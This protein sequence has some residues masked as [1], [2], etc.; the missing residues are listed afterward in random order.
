[1]EKTAFI[2]L[3]SSNSGDIYVFT[4]SRG[5]YE[6]ERTIEYPGNNSSPEPDVTG[7]G[8]FLLSLP[9]ELLNFR[10]LKL[11]F[12][13]KD[14][15]LKVVP[16]ELESLMMESPGDVVFDATVL[17]G[18]GEQFDVLV[19]YIGKSVLQDILNKLGLL[20]IDPRIVTC[21]ELRAVMKGGA[22][23]I[24]SRLLAPGKM[25]REQRIETA[26]SELLNET[27]N[28]RTG[29]LAYTKDTE[30]N[31]RKLK[32][33]AVLLLLLVL[34]VDSWLAFRIIKARNETSAVKKEL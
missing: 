17:G 11:P 32:T 22:E 16:F 2:D 8:E 5:K 24:A 10:L 21:L 30:K 27:V 28:L 6:L 1:M 29:T 14:K 7:V 15:L 18:A 25:G 33:A 3:N 31:T 23:D 4:N 20:L 19:T 13:D 34:L 9:A 12:S 26:K